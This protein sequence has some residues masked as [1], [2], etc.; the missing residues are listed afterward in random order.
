LSRGVLFFSLIAVLALAGC[1]SATG[2]STSAAPGATATATSAPAATATP[3]IPANATTIKISGAPGAYT[4]QPAT[5]TIKV[6]ETVVWDNVSGVPHTATSDS[7]DTVSWDSSLIASGGGSF[8]FVFSKPGTYPYHC[9]FHPF[10]HATII[11]T[12]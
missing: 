11:V 6:G 8:S 12:G 3:A 5:V 1:G 2:A 4:F 9:S 10:M 7:G